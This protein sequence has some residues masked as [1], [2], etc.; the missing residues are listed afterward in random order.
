MTGRA[1]TRPPGFLCGDTA[2]GSNMSEGIGSMPIT[3]EKARLNIW[4]LGGFI[5]GIIVTAFGW[6]VTYSSTSE[7][8]ARTQRDV[9]TIINEVKDIRLQLPQINALQFQMS[10]ATDA[11]S[12]NKAKIVATNDRVD[13]VVESFGGKLDSISEKINKLSI[14]IEVLNSRIGEKQ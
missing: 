3:I 5:A 6:G 8:N 7:A 1:T 4:N 12:E 11:I 14:N 2:S 13:R 9:I 10:R